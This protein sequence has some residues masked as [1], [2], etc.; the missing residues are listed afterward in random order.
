MQYVYG[1]I[2]GFQEVN[3]IQSPVDEKRNQFAPVPS[4]EVIRRLSQRKIND[5][6]S[7][8]KEIHTSVRNA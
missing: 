7:T 5:L 2:E 1:G 3:F 6:T 4:S 8:Q